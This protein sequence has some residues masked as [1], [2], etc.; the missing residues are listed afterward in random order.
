MPLSSYLEK[1]MLDWVCGGATP[2]QPVG[3]WLALASGTPTSLGNGA[4]E[5]G[6][7]SGYTRQSALFNSASTA[8]S[9]SCSNS[10]A[11]TFG[12]FS[13]VGTLLGVTIWDASPIGSTNLLWY[14]T[15]QTARTFSSGDYLVVQAGA[16]VLT[17]T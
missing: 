6:S 16:L 12:P 8:S 2:S 3:F 13:S 5:F 10:K 15:V 11:M 17:L 9:A 1:A 7:Q 14:G 4:S